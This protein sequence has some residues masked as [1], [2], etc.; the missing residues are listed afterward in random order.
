MTNEI[1]LLREDQVA[2]RLSVSRACLRKWRIQNR[3]PAFRKLGSLVRYRLDDVEAW[4]ETCPQGGE[5][6]R[7]Q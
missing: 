6:A 7:T 5:T 3:G 2:E 1:T 4:L